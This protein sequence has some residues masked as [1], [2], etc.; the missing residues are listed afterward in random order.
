MNSYYC[1]VTGI[2]F[3]KLLNVIGLVTVTLKLYVPFLVGSNL[4]ESDFMPL[5]Y[6]YMVEVDES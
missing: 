5:I 4:R 1:T 2:I 3:D 6:P